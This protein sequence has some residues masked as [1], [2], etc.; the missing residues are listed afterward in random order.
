M[1]QQMWGGIK[2]ACHYSGRCEKTLR[3]WLS[4]GLRH[5]RLPSGRILIKYSH[6]D[7]FLEKYAVTESEVDR[8]VDQI[9]R[10]MGR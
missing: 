2:D 5:S 1:A 3:G 9:L 4:S 6:I 7:E 10:E 8:Q